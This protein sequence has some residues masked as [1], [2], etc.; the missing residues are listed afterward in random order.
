MVHK[1]GKKA[2]PP[3]RTQIKYKIAIEN[4]EN[5]FKYTTII[6]LSAKN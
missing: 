2:N 1:N 3:K 6:I 5:K 4:K